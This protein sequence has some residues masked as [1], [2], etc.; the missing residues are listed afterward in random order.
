MAQR[1][2]GKEDVGLTDGDHFG[3]G[4]DV[5]NQVTVGQHDAFRIA[6][7]PR[8]VDQ[9]EQIFRLG[10]RQRVECIGM[11]L[12][13]LSAVLVH[14][15]ERN[16]PVTRGIPFIRNDD[17]VLERRNILRDFH[18]LVELKAVRDNR[19][20]YSRVVVDEFNLFGSKRGVDRYVDGTEGYHCHIGH[21][22]FRPVFGYDGD[23]ISFFDAKGHKAECEQFDISAA[24]SV[25][26]PFVDSLH[27]LHEHWSFGV[28]VP[29]RDVFKQ[30]VDRGE[31]DCD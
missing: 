8:R 11:T 15:P 12:L 4:N 29:F 14:L 30:F 13:I 5:G 16:N 22:P 31:L 10:P 17:H 28:G 7:R 19:D 26:D 2:E 1:K 21:D 18:D 25:A 3:R 6:R 20:L 27:P 23:P 9:R 24:F